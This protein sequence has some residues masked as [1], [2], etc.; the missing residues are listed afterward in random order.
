MNL[1]KTI[2]KLQSRLFKYR[3]NKKIKEAEKLHK[4]TRAHYLIMSDG[5]KIIIYRYK[6]AKILIAQK[7]FKGIKNM[8]QLAKKAVYS[9]K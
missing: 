2:N 7:R 5:K 9:T 6:M 1:L 4:I 8:E 3:L